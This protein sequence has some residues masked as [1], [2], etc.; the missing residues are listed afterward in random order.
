MKAFVAGATGETGRRIVQQ[1]VA[2]N[3]EVKALVRDRQTASEILPDAVEMVQANLQD[4]SALR[5]VMKD[6]DIILSATGARP[7]FNIA[8]PFQVDYIGT[9]NLVDAAQAEGLKQFI[10]VSS[11]CVSKFFHPLNLFWF[12]L[13]W[14]KQGETYLQNSGLSYTIV[15]P[16][17]LNLKM[18]K[19]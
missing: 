13:L 5:T 1:L 9:K 18:L 2:Q 4:M 7:S 11:L 15:R 8:G 17:G 12:I 19:L 3:I 10:M 14:K 6:C 16:G